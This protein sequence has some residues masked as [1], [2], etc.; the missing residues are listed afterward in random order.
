MKTGSLKALGK[1]W[2]LIME[3]GKTIKVPPHYIV[4]KEMD[5]AV[6]QYD[7]PGGKIDKILHQGSELPRKDARPVRQ[8]HKNPP[9]TKGYAGGGR[10]GDGDLT[11]RGMDGRW[12]K[13]ATYASAPYNFIPLPH[14]IVPA[15]EVTVDFS[16]YRQDLLSGYI[17]L[18]IEAKT[19]LFIRGEREK[20][21]SIAG[22]PSIPG[23]SMRGLIRSMVELV[24]FSKLSYSDGN[25]RFFYRN[26]NDPVYRAQF[27][28]SRKGDPIKIK[29]KGG[30]LVKK[31]RRYELHPVDKVY[32]VDMNRLLDPGFKRGINERNKCHSQVDVWYDP[33]K[34]DQ[35]KHKENLLL[36]YNTLKELH[37]SDRGSLL[38]GVL[39]RTG[40]LGD[41]KH[42]QWV[43]PVF[44]L[45]RDPFDVTTV[46]DI[47][48][49]DE[50]RDP[51]ADL[52][53]LSHEGN[54]V[55]CFYLTDDEG[56]PEFIG[57][58]GIFRIP[59]RKRVVDCMPTPGDAGMDIAESIFGG[60]EQGGSKQRSG[61][62][63]LRTASVRQ[64]TLR[65]GSRL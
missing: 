58:T 57:Q 4:P 41:R 32:R 35:F 15:P 6:V 50:N 61:R 53:K 37:L 27:L 59:Y 46:M 14:K 1:D 7:N 60:I 48:A 54:P 42:Y 63:F 65:A 20:F 29:S 3:N 17:D 12:N 51:S 52:V 38:K 11:K 33:A 13:P 62:V 49:S 25:R 56:K 26:I 34:V 5:G 22:R 18:E 23:S 8:E 30:Y 55:P 2:Q 40:P 39:I 19:D 44:T 9:A 16:S 28:G 43:L 31:G 36:E 24:S 47:Y 10:M 21:F 45:A 64:S